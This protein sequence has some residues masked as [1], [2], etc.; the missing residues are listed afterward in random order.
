MEAPES[1]SAW[2]KAMV[3]ASGMAGSSGSSIMAEA[4][5]LI[6][7]RQS[8]SAVQAWSMASAAESAGGGEPRWERGGGQPGKTEFRLADRRARGSDEHAGEIRAKKAAER[9]ARRAAPAAWA[10]RPCSAATM[11]IRFTASSAS[12]SSPFKTISCARRCRPGGDAQRAVKGALDAAVGEGLREEAAGD[13]F[14]GLSIEEKSDAGDERFAEREGIEQRFASRRQLAH[15][16]DASRTVAL[17]FD[18][19]QAVGVM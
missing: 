1:T 3:S 7:K 13:L 11:R 5:P 8:V 18:A 17:F 9:K 12:R 4:P 16:L 6:R 10:R 14:E 2:W 15:H 19:G